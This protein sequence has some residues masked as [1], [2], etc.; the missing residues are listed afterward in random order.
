[1]ELRKVLM[2]YLKRNNLSLS[3]CAKKIGVD[4]NNLWRWVHRNEKINQKHIEKI[5]EFLEGSF[6]V[7][8]EEILEKEAKND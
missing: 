3:F 2:L 8:L 7:P 6:L 5:K 4:V 1:M